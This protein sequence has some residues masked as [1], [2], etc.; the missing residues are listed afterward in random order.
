MR[1]VGGLAK[2]F[3]DV[4]GNGDWVELAGLWHDLGKYLPSWQSYL[5][6]KSGFDPDAHNETGQGRPNHSSSGAVYSFEKLKNPAI[7]RILAYMVSGHHAGLPDWY[8]DDAGGD[9]QNRIFKNNKLFDEEINIIKTVS[10]SSEFLDK[11][12][13]QTIPLNTKNPMELSEY[14]NLWIRMLFSCLVDADWL[15]TEKFMKPDQSSLRGLFPEIKDLKRR[16]DVFMEKKQKESSNVQINRRRDEILETC[17]AKASLE[18]GFFSLNVPTGGGKTLSSMAFALNHA[19]EYDKQRII[20]AIPYTSII[21]QTSKV[22]KYGTDDNEM[23]EKLPKSDWL[24][25][26]ESVLE[27]HSNIDPDNEM[28]ESK[29]AAENWDAPIIVTTNVQ[30]F[31]SL[32]SSRP[33]DCRK[34]HNIGNSIIILDEAQM[35]PPEY[36]KPILSVLKGLVLHFRV[37]VVLCTATQPAFEGKIG[38]QGTFFEGLGN[39]RPIIDKP[40]ELAKSFNRIKIIKPVDITVR[41]SWEELAETLSL[42]TQV[43][44]IVNRRTDCRELHRLMPE[45][46]IH[47][48]ALMCGEERSELISDIK[49][50]LRED[51]PVR[52]I[53]TQLVEAGVDIDFPVVYRALAGLDSIAQ[54]A[55][56]CNREGKLNEKGMIGNV[57]IFNPP[58]S[59]PPGLLRKGED[60]SKEILRLYN[61]IELS[62][63]LFEEYFK[64]FYAS[65]NDF[66]KPKFKNRLIDEAKEFKFQFRTFA[67]DF[68]LIDD[69]IQKGIFVWYKGMKFDSESLIDDLKKY[70]PN[71]K[72]LRRLQRFTVNVPLY[73]LKQLTEK[74]LVSDTESHGYFVQMSDELYKKG[75]GL[76][77]DADWDS[78]KFVC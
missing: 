46:T 2:S 66:D 13:P 69:S 76:Y 78:G 14:F 70:G 39:V 4:F 68:K 75:S 21:E 5:C 50:K 8:P 18:P 53:S 47:L 35:L 10:E 48:S 72:L 65:V 33:S 51:K 19:L 56:R 30:L 45:G 55:G 1:G 77:Y 43:L 62:P 27:H 34:L 37:T 61:D 63:D 32:F 71:P 42:Y 9:L 44:C 36:L 22:Y 40:K 7:A 28:T 15:D 16:F 58:K 29:L 49:Q 24:F 17:R 60:T 12:S 64:R 26:E 73:V 25:G 41:Q 31:E 6:R 74:G 11:D 38:S 54:A 52:V 57:Y 3:A 59:S 23:I 67:K 20:M